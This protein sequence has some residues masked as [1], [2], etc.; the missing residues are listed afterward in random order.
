MSAFATDT[1]QVSWLKVLVFLKA[2]RNCIW[3]EVFISVIWKVEKELKKSR[4]MNVTLE[5]GS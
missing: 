2:S 1:R 5:D 3:E 4:M